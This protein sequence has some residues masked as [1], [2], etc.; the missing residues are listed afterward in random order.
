MSDSSSEVL[1]GKE[2]AWPGSQNQFPSNSIVLLK[3]VH[4]CCAPVFIF[5]SGRSAMRKRLFSSQFSLLIN[6]EKSTFC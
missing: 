1:Y 4:R 6:L 3:T 5:Q 2:P